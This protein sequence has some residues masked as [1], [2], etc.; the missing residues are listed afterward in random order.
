MAIVYSPLHSWVTL[1]IYI[2]EI[3]AIVF[4]DFTS[5][6]KVWLT[7]VFAHK[8]RRLAD[9]CFIDTLGTLWELWD[10][11]KIYLLTEG[12]SWIGKEILF[13]CWTTDFWVWI[14]VEFSHLLSNYLTSSNI[15]WCSFRDQH[16]PHFEFTKLELTPFEVCGLQVQ[17]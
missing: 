7:W 6:A 17:T 8:I 15:F 10:V 11:L 4:S 13:P 3:K 12:R 14:F 5:F 9:I 1:V 2:Q 16:S